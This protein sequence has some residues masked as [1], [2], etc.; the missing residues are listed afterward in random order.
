M[1]SKRDARDSAR[2]PAVLPRTIGL[3]LGLCAVLVALALLAYESGKVEKNTAAR[4]FFQ[5][6]LDTLTKPAVSI[7]RGCPDRRGTSTGDPPSVCA[8]C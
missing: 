5:P 6:I 2:L 1:G 4:M 8:F 7:P 3:F